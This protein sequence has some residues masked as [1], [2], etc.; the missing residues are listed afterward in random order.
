MYVPNTHHSMGWKS[1]T[2][3]DDGLEREREKT[4]YDV[5]LPKLLLG[6]V[7]FKVYE[8]RLGLGG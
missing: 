4:N 5:V 6:F 1:E 7:T 2:V 8:E 3:P